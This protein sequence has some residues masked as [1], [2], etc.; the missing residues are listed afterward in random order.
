LVELVTEYFEGALSAGERG[1]VERHLAA[2]D[3]CDVY[4]EQMR[5]TLGA[6][7]ALRVEDLSPDAQAK[8]SDV[9]RAWRA[10][11]PFSPPGRRPN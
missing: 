2:C 3:G 6:L 9:F 1:R 10:E 7:G 11:N 8:L 5:Q 4:V